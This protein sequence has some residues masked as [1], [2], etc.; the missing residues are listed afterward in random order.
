M[1]GTFWSEDRMQQ[2]RKEI[3]SEHTGVET[4]YNYSPTRTLDILTPPE[5][6]DGRPDILLFDFPTKQEI[7]SGQK[8]SLTTDDPKMRPLPKFA[9]LEMQWILHRL[10]AMSGVA[11]IHD[12]FDNDDDDAMPLWN[13]RDPYEGGWDSYVEDDNWNSYKG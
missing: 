6:S 13:E 2:W 4:C 7:C 1:L 10:A 9:L 5:G 8:I 11:E 3:F 12:D